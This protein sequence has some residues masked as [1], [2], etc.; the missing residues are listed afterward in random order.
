[1]I[2]DTVTSSPTN[3]MLAIKARPHQD[4]TER[5]YYLANVKVSDGTLNWY[6]DPGANS[7]RK[8]YYQSVLVISSTTYYFG[9]G[10]TDSND[11][12]YYMRF[13]L[14]GANVPSSTGVQF[15]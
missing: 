8:I 14:N 1:M 3:F 4:S 6:I 11:N 2:Y 5:D 13:I 15:L 10:K 12:P 7:G 9:C